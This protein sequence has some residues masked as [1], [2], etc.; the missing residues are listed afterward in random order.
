MKNNYCVYK[1]TSPSGK[2]YIGITNQR[3]ERRWRGGAGYIQRDG[4]PTPFERAITKYGWDNFTHEILDC[5]LTKEEACEM[6]R[7]YIKELKTQDRRYGYNVL[8]GGEIPLY[9]C[10]QSVRDKM[11]DSAFKKWER[12]EYIESHTGDNHWTRKQGYS[13]NSIDAMRARNLGIKR[14]PEQIEFLRG[15]GRKQKRLIGKDNKKSIP[16]LCYSRDGEL[17][18]KYYG[19]LEA[20][21]TTGVCFQNIFKVCNG[22]RKTAGGYVWRYEREVLNDSEE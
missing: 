8:A 19:A 15:K 5:N 14:T 11:R 2:S 9:E 21:R 13:Q 7:A 17:L 10:P 12:E 6:E 22:E 4:N 20:E 16:I 1:H 3:P 18:A